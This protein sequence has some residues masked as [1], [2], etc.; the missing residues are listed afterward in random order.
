MAN[1]EE[2]DDSLIDEELLYALIC[3]AEELPDIQQEETLSLEKTLNSEQFQDSE[4]KEVD[5]EEKGILH[6]DM[7]FQPEDERDSNMEELPAKPAEPVSSQKRRERISSGSNM[8]TVITKGTLI[9]GKIHSDC[10]LDVLGTVE[11]DIECTG[12]LTVSG[13]VTG[14]LKAQ[15][16]YVD[17]ERL[18][19]SIQSEG[20][21]K[22]GVGTVI[23]GDITAASG[24][25][26][27]AVKGTIDISG[28]VLLDSTAIIQG[29]ICAKSIQMAHGAVLEGYCSLR[30]ASVEIDT[31]FE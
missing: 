31:I 9:Q 19:G 20:A 24:T 4:K 30:Y 23:I 21:V 10:S 1:L 2:F 29:N 13:K 6:E 12:S 25:I 17:T 5:L 3:G 16:V 8:V 27:G 18:N 11:G 14:N 15:E 7:E 22:I 26:A 28:P